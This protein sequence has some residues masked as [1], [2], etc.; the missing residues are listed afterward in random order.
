MARAGD[1]AEELRMLAG[2]DP[3]AVSSVTT[4]KKLQFSFIVKYHNVD[5]KFEKNNSPWQ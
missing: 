4:G 3:S 5:R 2:A 1:G